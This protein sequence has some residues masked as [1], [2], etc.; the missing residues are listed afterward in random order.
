DAAGREALRNELSQRLVLPYAV[1]AAGLVLFMALIHFSSLREPELEAADAPAGEIT[2][3][4][5]FRH[6]QVVLGALALFG[7]VGV[8]VI[9]GDT[10]GLYGRQ[11]G[12]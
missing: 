8:E 7:Y 6:P 10:I 2:R 9:A 1:M 3:W 4:G 12:V 11:L 5:V